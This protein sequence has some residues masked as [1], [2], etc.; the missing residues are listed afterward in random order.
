VDW[1]LAAQEPN[2]A[3]TRFVSILT[4]MRQDLPVLRRNRF[5]TGDGDEETGIT[6]VRWLSPTGTDLTQEQWSDAQMHSFGVLL[7]GRARISE[8][9][10]RASDATVLMFLN[11]YHDPV[12]FVLPETAG[13]DRWILLI[14][15][16]LPLPKERTEFTTGQEY[17]VTGRSVVVFGL[18]AEG[19]TRQ[20]LLDLEAAIYLAANAQDGAIE[21]P[22]TE[23]NLESGTESDA[24]PAQ[25]ADAESADENRDGSPPQ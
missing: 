4:R 23:L 12:N 16:R 1:E 5:L 13:P 21:E 22:T 7:D 15:T 20:V 17:M 11:A 19:A 2:K 3:L 10:R 25:Q 14:D 8:I 6:D 18:E 24:E 9:R